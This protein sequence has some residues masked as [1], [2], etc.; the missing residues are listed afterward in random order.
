MHWRAVLVD[1]MRT[2]TMAT[3]KTSSGLGTMRSLHFP[4]SPDVCAFQ[5]TQRRWWQQ[6]QRPMQGALGQCLDYT[7]TLYKH[8]GNW[9]CCHTHGGNVGNGHTSSTCAH[10]SPLHNPNKMRANMMNGFPT[11]LHKT[12]LPLASGL[13]PH[14]LH[15]QC[16]PAPTSWQ[17]PP[18]PVNF[19]NRIAPM[20]PPMPYHQMHYMGQQF[21]PTPPPGTQPAP[22]AP[23]PPADTMMVPYYA[24]Y[25]QPHPF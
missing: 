25:P 17:Q 22:P 1:T 4:V 2:K 21:G 3:K 5:L 14:I 6:R 12:I 18:P 7:P 13:A 9:N 8:L 24:P 16:A 23:A 20:M 19:T 15:Q 10:P 11:G